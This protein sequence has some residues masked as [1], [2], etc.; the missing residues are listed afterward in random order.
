MVEQSPRTSRQSTLC[1][2]RTRPVLT[3]CRQVP[4][5]TLRASNKCYQRRHRRV[6]R[7]ITQGFPAFRCFA[8]A[9]GV[10][11]QNLSHS[12]TASLASGVSGKRFAGLAWAV[13]NWVLTSFL[14]RLSNSARQTRM[15]PK[16]RFE[17]P[18]EIRRHAQQLA[19]HHDVPTSILLR[20]NICRFASKQRLPCR[21][22]TSV[23]CWIKRPNQWCQ[24][25]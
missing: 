24:R 5:R 10:L 2:L 11:I 18:Q 14:S 20:I 4:G 1:M 22:E 23:Q 3:R 6:R 12:Q 9:N 17:S 25:D 21:V 13:K 8:T 16:N 7:V 15:T 19:G